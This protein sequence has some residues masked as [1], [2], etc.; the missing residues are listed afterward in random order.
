[1]RYQAA[2]EAPTEA[3]L[4]PDTVG[5]WIVFEFA[6]DC[7]AFPVTR[8]VELA[9]AM[10]A[11]ILA[12][13]E[14]PIPEAI[15]GHRPDGRPTLSPHVATV[16]IPHVAFPH[17]D[18][19]MLGVAVSVPDS[20]DGMSRTALHR[21]IGLW[22]RTVL[23]DRDHRR[24][25]LTLV[26]GSRSEVHLRRVPGVSELKQL[27][28]RV[29][30]HRPSRR[31]LS[32]TPVALPRHP[33]SLT[34]GSHAV[35]AKAWERAEASVKL[36]CEHV[37]L[38]DP[39][40]VRLSLGPM[41]SGA[42]RVADFP[43]FHQAGRKGEPVRRQLVNVSL[44][45]QDRVC[46]AV[47]ARCR[48]VLR[49]RPH[50]AVFGSAASLGPPRRS[51]MDRLAAGD[52]P[53]YFRGV[54]GYDPFPWQQRLTDQVLSAGWPATIDLPTGTGKTAVLDTAVFALACGPADAPRR[55]V[56][57][58]D[59]R[60]VVDQVYERARQIRDAISSGGTEVLRRVRERIN[61]LADGHPLGVV[62]LRGGIPIEREWTHRPE[63][64]WVLVSTVDQFGSR[65]LFRGYGV[66]RR[67]H[68]VHAGLAGN[69]CLVILDEV[70]LSAPFAETLDQVAALPAG[71]LP[72]RYGIVHMSA[73]P[74]SSARGDTFRLDPVADLEECAE[75]RQRVLAEKRAEL[76]NVT[77]RKSVPS[78]VLRIVK[79]IKKSGKPASVGSLGV[80]VNRI[81]TAREA[82]QVLSKAGFDVHLVTGRMRPLDRVAVLQAIR[83]A[84]NPERKVASETD[85]MTVVVAT[86]AIEVGADFSFDALVTECAPVDCLR[87]RFG[88][89]DRR[90]TY[91]RDTESPARA[92]ILGIRPE[93][94]AK[95]PDPIYGDA[96]KATWGHLQRLAD[97]R[98]VDVGPQSL[99]GFLDD[100]LALRCAAPLLLDTHVDAWVQTNPQPIV[101]PPIDW[102]LHGIDR[103]GI[104]E[105]SIV[106]RLDR[107][108]RALELVPPQQAESLS[109]PIDAAR[110]WLSGDSEIDFADVQRFQPGEDE[111]REVRG[112][113]R[114]RGAGRELDEIA[115]TGDIRPGDTLV[116]DPSRG[117]LH[118]Q[119]W[120]PAAEGEVP[121][122][123]DAAQAAHR[124]RVTL[125]LDKRVP[126]P[127]QYSAA[128]PT[129][130][131]ALDPDSPVR[132]PRSRIPEWLETE[133]ARWTPDEAQADAVVD[134]RN[135]MERLMIRG[136]ESV[137]VH[138][139]ASDGEE[140]YVLVER[141]RRTRGPVVDPAVLDG[142]D[143]DASR[144][145]SAVTLRRHLAGV[146]ARVTRIGQSLGLPSPLVDDLRLAA[147]YHDIGKI[148]RRFQA[149]LVGGEVALA[150]LDEPLAKSVPGT[151]RV[152]GYPAG[153]RHELASVALLVSDRTALATASDPDLVLHL[154]GTHHGWSRPLPPGIEDPDLDC[155]PIVMDRPLWRRTATSHPARWHLRWLIDSGA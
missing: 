6:H 38:P 20:I 132:D 4:A 52:F 144:T 81:R 116:V 150:M 14:D 142:S 21:A 2:Q 30:W 89:L 154:I 126:S 97:D 16:P 45:F 11:E 17:A 133:V 136:F 104:P 148:D 143:D 101:Q 114:W 91:F 123:G 7:R 19:R 29:W 53:A 57:V 112:C 118:A 13:A 31:W 113:V 9:S 105:V 56:F 54:H 43:P 120:D 137:L 75:L 67:M 115:S 70:H 41:M 1:M 88:R 68:P 49:S 145:D 76:V 134:W 73:T 60:I 140:Y 26:M 111:R 12:H 130:G 103:S 39:S 110:S 50:A 107:R 117:G 47:H 100:A 40:E 58:I 90:G 151:P 65:L 25:Y 77:N 24:G 64:P 85:E 86:Q 63:Q 92:W 18:G 69:D 10:R 71:R 15:S 33:G 149:Q 129:P 141:N 146:A 36:A 147:E 93:L 74:G 106:W 5:D 122:L 108:R 83:H 27:R 78:A 152:Q 155:S 61:E 34:R 72:K 119:T 80:V 82:H 127:I 66:S 98:T 121:D 35:R 48:A 125:R 99:T 124:R 94:N 128:P 84:V 139:D 96:V 42:R 55:V 46:G 3:L 22:E 87:Q 138:G 62:A 131:D 79:A 8:G 59:R 135:V 28:P 153:M 102:F 37:G 32:A 44:T 23:D 109:V 51:T 95:R